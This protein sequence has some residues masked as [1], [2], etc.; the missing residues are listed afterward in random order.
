MNIWFIIWALIA[1]GL[2]GFTGWSFAVLQRQKR[3]WASFGKKYKLR[4]TPG[5]AME[6]PTLSGLYDGYTLAVFVDL[7]ASADGRRARRLSAIEVT[8]HTNMAADGALASR[9]MVS[10]VEALD[11]K[12]EVKPEHPKWDDSFICKTS[13]K[14]VM[15]AYLTP[16]RLDHL[17]KLMSVENAAVIHIFRRDIMLLRFDTPDPIDTPQKLDRLVKQMIAAAKALEVDESL[18]QDN[19]SSADEDTADDENE[20]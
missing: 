17:T 3:A 15:D 9:D 18:P 11:F 5:T 7:H 13:K 14:A 1:V 10:I 19:V 2:F 8:L 16:E 20:A 6:S 12:T 4:Y